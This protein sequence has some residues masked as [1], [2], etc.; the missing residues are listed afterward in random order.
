ML[1]GYVFGVIGRAGA[2]RTYRYVSVLGERHRSRSFTESMYT[3]GYRLRRP[4]LTLGL[5]RLFMQALA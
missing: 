2:R 4:K 1:T 5:D 3:E